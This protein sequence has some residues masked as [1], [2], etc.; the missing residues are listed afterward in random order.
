VSRVGPYLLLSTI[1]KACLTCLWVEDFVTIRA[2]SM[3]A[4]ELDSGMGDMG[5]LSRRLCTAE[6]SIPACISSAGK[7]Y[8]QGL[9]TQ[10]Q[11]PT[12][13]Q[14]A[15]RIVMNRQNSTNSNSAGNVAVI[16]AGTSSGSSQRAIGCFC[17]PACHDRGRWNLGGN[18]AM[19]S[20]ARS[21]AR[22][23]ICVS[24]LACRRKRSGSRAVKLYRFVRRFQ[25]YVYHTGHRR[26]FDR[27]G[28]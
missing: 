8:H 15:L 23:V 16:F 19:G 24:S 2:R 6:F 7:W 14:R 27:R 20:I 26:R 4:L 3:S 25:F 18:A 1:R 5:F 9:R 13:S 28:A 21:A 12:P 22:R 11:M 17:A 10:F